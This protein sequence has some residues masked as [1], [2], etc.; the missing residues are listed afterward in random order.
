MVLNQRAVRPVGERSFVI[1]ST[2]EQKAKEKTE[3]RGKSSGAR[4]DRRAIELVDER[5]NGEREPKRIESVDF[6]DLAS[7]RYVCTAA[8]AAAAVVAGEGKN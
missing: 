3:H 1:L 6:R 5:Q 7:G 4:V 2:G 8:A